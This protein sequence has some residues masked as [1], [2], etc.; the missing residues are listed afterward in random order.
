M[1]KLKRACAA[2]L[3]LSFCLALFAACGKDA[4]AVPSPAPEVTGEDTG[5]EK[6]EAAL[7]DGEYTVIFKTDSSMFHIN[8]ALDDKA[9]LTVKNGEMTVHATLASKKILNLFAGLKEDAQKEG[10]ALLQPTSDSVTYKDG[11]T[12]EVYGFDIP[13]PYL[14][15]EFPCALIGKKGVWYDHTVTVTLAESALPDGEY[16]CEVAL[17]GGTG[18]ASV[19]SPAKI[20]VKDGQAYAEIVWSSPNYDYMLVGDARFEPVNADGKSV[21]VIPV[22]LYSENAVQADTVAMSQPHLID[23]TLIF[24]P[25]TLK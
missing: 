22:S 13:V 19:Q 12:E 11:T 4:P 7:P 25:T 18:R 24:D 5:A 23:Y 14:D 10:A 15:R 1:D 3:L 2:C 17:S 8:E 21:F 6:A 16:T 20:T 9:T